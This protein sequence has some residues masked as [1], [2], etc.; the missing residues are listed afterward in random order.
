MKRENEEVF[1]KAALLRELST[2][3]LKKA[4]K[5]TGAQLVAL[6]DIS[7][8]GAARTKPNYEKPHLIKGYQKL[9]ARIKT[10]LRERERLTRN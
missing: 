5:E 1:V 8:I 10:I 9:I 6:R 2:E 4:L 7:A 3:E